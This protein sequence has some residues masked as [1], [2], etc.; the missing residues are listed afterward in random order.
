[1]IAR[2]IEDAGDGIWLT[3]AL[4][5]L[6]RYAGV[7]ARHAAEAPAVAVPKLWARSPGAARRG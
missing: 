5:D 1:M 4:L 7:Y 3:Y 2:G 6:A